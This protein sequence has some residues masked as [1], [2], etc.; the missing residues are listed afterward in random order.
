[1]NIIAW[2]ILGLLAGAIAKSIYPGGQGGGI[3]ATT[4]LGIIGAFVG[5]TLYTLLKTGT[6]SLTSTS[7]DLVG[8]FVS[9]IG[10][11]VAL[12]I[13]SLLLQNRNT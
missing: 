10:A 1:M 6:F 5:G 13:W 12:F 11:V 9:V 8:L 4:G 7:F 2:L 3:F